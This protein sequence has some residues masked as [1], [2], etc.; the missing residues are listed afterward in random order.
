[1]QIESFLNAIHVLVEGSQTHDMD[2]CRNV[3][4]SFIG[5]IFS[6]RRT[7][8]MY[9]YRVL[10]S[11]IIFCAAVPLLV[12]GRCWEDNQQEHTIADF[13]TDPA[14]LEL[15][16]HGVEEGVVGGRGV[17][18]L[19]LTSCCRRDGPRGLHPRGA[20]PGLA[21]Q[22]AGPGHGHHL[23]LRGPGLGG[24]AGHLHPDHPAA[25]QRAGHPA[26]TSSN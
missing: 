2:L 10:Q 4:I 17:V 1:M 20:A 14:T 8:E 19:R 26:V 23:L 3:E 15:L 6:L 12:S 21:R 9:L 13:K 7:H 25:L 5:L 18:R 24:A 22:P 11:S 16:A